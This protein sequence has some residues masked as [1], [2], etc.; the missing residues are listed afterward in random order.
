MF[1][2]WGLTQLMFGVLYM[3]AMWRG[4]SL[5]SLMWLFIFAEWSGRLLIGFDKPLETIGTALGAIGK[6]IF[7]VLALVML[8][9][10]IRKSK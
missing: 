10:S 9:L 8:A 3:L 5:I 1:A 4:Q 6:L 7:P 2:Q